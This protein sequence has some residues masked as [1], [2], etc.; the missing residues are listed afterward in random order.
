MHE[1]LKDILN[2]ETG[3]KF[4]EYIVSRV[5]REDY[6]GVHRSQHNR[7]D[8]DK[9]E[10][11]LRAIHDIAGENGFSIPSGDIG[12]DIEKLNTDKSNYSDFYKIYK[13]LESEEVISAPDPL[14]KNFFVEFSRLGFLEKYNQEG[15]LLN[16]F[17]R[18]LTKSVKLSSE[19]I[20]FLKAETLFDKHKIFTE[21]VERLL[22]DTLI[23]LVSAIDL[24]SYYRHEQFYFEEYTL[25]FSDD[26]L[27][28]TEKIEMVK[29]WRSLGRAQRENTLELIKDYCN[30]QR[31]PGDRTDKRDYHNWRNE[32]Q[33]LMSLFKLTVY[34]QVYDDRFSLNIGQSFGIF[35]RTRREEPKKR[36]FEKHGIEKQEDYHLHHIVPLNYVRNR[37][38]YRLIDDFRNLIYVHKDKHKEIK[39][40]HIIFTAEDPEVYFENRFETG[41]IVTARRGENTN[42]DPSLLN[43]MQNYNS[44]IIENLGLIPSHMHSSN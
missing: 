6:R 7:Y 29:H 8:L 33:Q 37:E 24:S 27:S 5:T 42:F 17:C 40:D 1:L 16:P 30:P 20:R 26:R 12:Q 10:K 34:F 3:N 31:F 28:G 35:E 21:G 14:R 41:N 39:R 18:T 13:I 36:Y 4:L 2:I 32:T 9:F 43:I 38:E 15:K 44:E 25:I 11:I 19:G 23:D 22:G